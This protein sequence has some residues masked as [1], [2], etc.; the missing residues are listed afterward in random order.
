MYGGTSV[1]HNQAMPKRSID[2]TRRALLGGLAAAVLTPTGL[3]GAAGKAK[4]PATSPNDPALERAYDLRVA[5]AREARDLGVSA[6][7]ANGDEERLAGRIAC[8]TK[9][10]PHDA[11]GLVEPK[12]YEVLRR[13]LASGEPKDFEVVPL[14]GFV[15][16]ANPQAAWS[17]GL[18]GPAPSQLSCPPAPAF[19]G[20]EQAAEMVEL[21]WQALLR[22]VPFAEYGRHPLARAACDE[23]SRLPGFRGPLAAG[24]VTPETLFRGSTAGDLAGPYLSQFLLKPIPMVPTIIEQKN[25]TAVPGL[26]YLTDRVSWL[27]IQNGALAGV[28]RFEPKP[29]FQ[30]NGRDLGEYVHRDFSYQP[31]LAACL[32]A[33]KWGTQPDG[34]NPYK[35]SRTQSAFATFGQ[36][37]LLALLATVT[38]ASLATCW[39]Q[40]WQVHRRLRPEEMGGRIEIARRGERP[41]PLPAGLL[42]SAALAEVEKRFGTALL[43]QAYPEGC[44]IHPSYP[45]GH[46]VIA[47]ACVT[48]LKACLDESHVVPEPVVPGS[49]GLA[50]SPYQGAPLSVGGELDKLAGNVSLGRNFA[51]LHWRSDAREGLLLGEELAIR[52]LR[53]MKYTGNEIFESWSLRRFDGRRVAV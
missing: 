12:S 42:D 32:Q 46:A 52:V 30:R 20:P 6:Q 5:A 51:G 1:A 38:Q 16:L 47:G 50:L 44:P 40:K 48:A 13:A 37:Y 45:A 18:I 22:D 3:A 19:D 7:M 25:R 17:V 9:G 29:L 33:L 4:R 39:Y 23:L 43:P 2:P 31:Y 35:H 15:K 49:D 14:G 36:P 11:S 26:D 34:G 53:E 27:A 24:Q 8:F 28:N 10:L 21:W 41:L